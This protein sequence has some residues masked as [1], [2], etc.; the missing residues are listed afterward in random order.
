M[1]TE[2]SSEEIGASY[3]ELP[4]RSVAYPT[5]SPE[6]IRAIARL[7]GLRPPELGVAR[8]L[9]LGCAAGGNVIPF[10]VRH[11]R[12]EVVGVDLSPVQITRGNEVV[13]AMGLG[14]VQL[15]YGD[16]EQLDESLGV[17]DY[18]VCHGVYS[19]VPDSV[20]AAIMQVIRRQLAANGVAYVSYNA[21]PGWKAKEVIRDAMRSIIGEVKSATGIARARH[22]AKLLSRIAP[23][24][25]VLERT[26]SEHGAVIENSA[27]HYVRH[28]Y[29]SLYN[30][31]FYLRDFVASAERNGLTYLGDAEVDTMFSSKISGLVEE[32][33]LD[34]GDQVFI[35]QLNDIAE[36]RAFRQTL[37]VHS[38]QAGHINYVPDI[39][40]LL[41]L[42]VASRITVTA[43]GVIPPNEGAVLNGPLDAV[44]SRIVEGL[45]AAWPS[46]IPVKVLLAGCDRKQFSAATAFLVGLISQRVVRFRC[47]PVRPSPIGLRPCVR[48]SVRRLVAFGTSDVGV[49]NEWHDPVTLSDLERFLL[50][51]MDGARGCDELVNEVAAAIES[52]SLTVSGASDPDV[53]NGRMDD[54]ISQLVRGAIELVASK[55]LLSE[56][57]SA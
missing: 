25:S 57:Q 34:G 5:T 42:H 56:S 41:E 54:V 26:M 2:S 13:R 29:L 45:N 16:V 50:L 46:T 20:R 47:E 14:N 3:D 17:F 23:A 15:L 55:A 18:I 44:C 48:E 53:L 31:P 38:E 36:N 10:A 6:H 43:P 28:E 22:L 27:D 33:G 11:P 49:F 24:G 4:Y 12:A 19:W 40:R 32:L 8:V 7:F 39:E 9:E 30:A 21:Y 37:L 1:R 52:G 35:E 51:R